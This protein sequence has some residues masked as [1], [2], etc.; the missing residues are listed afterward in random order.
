MFFEPK[1]LNFGIFGCC[2]FSEFFCFSCASLQRRGLCPNLRL[3]ILGLWLCKR[4]Q[5]VL[6]GLDR[7]SI[8]LPLAGT[9]DF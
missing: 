6:A 5:C 7:C 4:F 9:A 2:I 3:Q 8:F 1:M